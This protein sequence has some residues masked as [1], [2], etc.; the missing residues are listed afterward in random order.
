MDLSL[1]WELFTNCIQASEIL[2]IDLSFRREL[3]TARE[4]L[5]PL[6]V[7]RHGQL[8]EWCEDFE[9][10]EPGHRHVSHLYGLFPGRQ[11]LKHKHPCLS[12]A[13]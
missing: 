1:I 4:Q 9:E 8:Q 11:I 10:A 12:R 5:L 3:E 2:G 13:C 6:R 7:G